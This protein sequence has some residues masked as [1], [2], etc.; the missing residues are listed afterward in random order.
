MEKESKKLRNKFREHIKLSGK[1]KSLEEM[2]EIQEEG[3]ILANRILNN[4]NCLMIADDV[5]LGKTYEG[6]GII[7]SKFIEKSGQNILIIA[8]NEQI[9]LKWKKEYDYFKDNCI[10]NIKDEKYDF[11]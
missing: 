4:K 7:F 5:G 3:I 6:L 10:I 1:E 2:C 9:G 11:N 8:P